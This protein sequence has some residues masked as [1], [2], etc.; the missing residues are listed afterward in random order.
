MKPPSSTNEP[1]RL[2]FFADRNLGPVFISRL[3]I[4]GLKVEACDDHFSPFAKDVEW[5]PVVAE[6]GW[7]AITQDQLRERPEEQEALVLHGAKVFVLMGRATHETLAE[8]F[9][10]RQKSIQRLIETHDDAFLAK[11]YLRT[12]EIKVITASAL[13]EKLARRWQRGRNR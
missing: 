5:I 11:L 1:R 12:G 8:I 4:G 2:T 9:L 7:V 3:R 10:A 13:Y 6:R